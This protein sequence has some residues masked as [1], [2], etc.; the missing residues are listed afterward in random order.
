[1]KLLTEEAVPNLSE[2]RPTWGAWIETIL[3]PSD[4]LRSLCRA[5]RGA[6]GLKRLSLRRPPAAQGVA[7]HVGRVD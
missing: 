3:P 1:M 6:R 2:S 5:S 7:P 4:S